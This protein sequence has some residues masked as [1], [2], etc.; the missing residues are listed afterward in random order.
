MELSTIVHASSQRQLPQLPDAY[1]PMNGSLRPRPTSCPFW[2]L[3][4]SKHFAA[5]AWDEAGFCFSGF[6]YAWIA[7]ISGWMPMMFITLVRL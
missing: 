3:A 4:V 5:K 2:A 6:D 7:A 1:P